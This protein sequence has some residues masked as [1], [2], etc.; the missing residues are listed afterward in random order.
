MTKTRVDHLPFRGK[1]MDFLGIN[2]AILGDGAAGKTAILQRWRKNVFSEQHSPTVSDV[3]EEQVHRQEET[4]DINLKIYDTAGSLAFPA[5]NR[6]TIM[7]SDAFVV[8]YAVNSEKSFKAAK[9]LVEEVKDIKTDR[10]PCVV[11]GNKSDLHDTREVSF[12]QGLQLAVETKAPFMEVSAKTG[13]NI[14]DIFLTL[15]RRFETLEKLSSVNFLLHK[16]ERKRG[17]LQFRKRSKSEH[18]WN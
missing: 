17:F 7:H 8:V 1:R 15:L 10:I 9:R 12:E 14:H 11:V 16:L 2:V 6:I 4:S 18:T 13:L 5:M 3:F